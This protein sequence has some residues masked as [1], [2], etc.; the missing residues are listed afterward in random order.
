LRLVR[1][2]RG[3]TVA[4]QRYRGPAWLAALGR[5]AREAIYQLPDEI[6]GVQRAIAINEI[7]NALLNEASDEL[8]AA[9][10][11]IREPVG[12]ALLTAVTVD[13][14]CMQLEAYRN[15]DAAALSVA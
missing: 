12:R 7:T 13:E 6:D 8:R 1:A 11:A 15:A 2:R 10:T 5:S 9:I 4:W 3:F 14:L